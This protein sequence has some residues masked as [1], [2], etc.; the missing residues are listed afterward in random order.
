MV[1][2]P[3]L[4]VLH[5][6]EALGQGGAEQ[7]LLSILRQL[8]PPRFRHH[9][10]WLRP[11]PDELYGAF[12]PLVATMVPLHDGPRWSHGRA[13]R[14]LLRWVRAHRPALLHAQMLWPQLISRAA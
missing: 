13:A 7:N 4:D 9:L 1:A 3:P 5:V 6:F 10:A 14:N 8:P 11:E 2:G 12:A